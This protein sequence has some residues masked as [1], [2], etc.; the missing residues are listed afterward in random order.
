MYWDTI[1]FKKI[2]FPSQVKGKK[3]QSS[4]IMYRNVQIIWEN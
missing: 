3:L 4:Y 2:L 1:I